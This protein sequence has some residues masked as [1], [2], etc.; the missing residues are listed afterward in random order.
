[1]LYRMQEVIDLVERHGF[2]A[3]TRMAYAIRLEEI[4]KAW[5][6][7]NRIVTVLFAVMYF[8]LLCVTALFVPS[9]KLPP[10][11][12]DLVHGLSELYYYIPE[13]VIFKGLELHAASTLP[14]SGRGLDLGCGN[15][16]TGTALIKSTGIQALHGIDRSNYFIAYSEY[17]S[18]VLGDVRSLPYADNTFDFVISLGVI[19]HVD[20][21]N[22]VLSEACRVLRPGGHLTFAIQTPFFRESTF[23]YNTFYSLGMRKKAESFKLY[24]DVFD[25]IFHYYGEDDWRTHL[26]DAGF[27]GVEI[28]YVFSGKHLFFYDLLNMQVYFLKFYYAQHAQQFFGRHARMRRPVVWATERIASYI[29]AKPTTRENATRYFIRATK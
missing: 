22:T 24:R 5:T 17:A 6:W 12:R 10:R 25:M 18:Y 28:D 20:E 2:S 26:T 19:D 21:L 13:I 16:L 4:G 14:Y 27:A 11:L 1:M 3:A 15:G 8:V 29:I 23:W 7:P 9:T